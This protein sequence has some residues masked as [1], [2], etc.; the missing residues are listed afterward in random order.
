MKM[1]ANCMMLSAASAVVLG[2]L[3][4][5]QT[6]NLVKAAVPFAFETT[7]GTMPAGE[8]TITHHDAYGGLA[9]LIFHNKTT[10]QNM[11]AVGSPADSYK[12][13]SPAILFQCV[14]GACSLTGLRGE[15]GAVAINSGRKAA[16]HDSVAA[17]AVP[18]RATV[19]D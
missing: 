11:L 10:G 9:L 17:I 5:A 18:L 4:Y 12:A 2:T 13:G 1:F 8:Y 15:N 7:T 3:A 6:P 14:N 19:A 16:G